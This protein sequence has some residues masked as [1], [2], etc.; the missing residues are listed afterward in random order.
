MNDTTLPINIGS[1]L[2]AISPIVL[3]LVLLAVLRWK[4]PQAGPVGMFLAV[5]LALVFFRTPWQTVAVGAGKGIWDA[6]FILLVIWPALL[7]YRIGTAAGAFDALRRGLS[8]YSRNHVFLVLAFGWVFASFVQG[9][10]GFGAPIAIVAPLLLAIGVRAVYAVAIPLIGHAWANMFGT[11][12]VGWLATL[13]VVEL[14]DELTTALVT[15]VLLAPVTLMAGVTIAWMAG[16]GAAVRLAWPLILIISAI[17]AGLQF[18]IMYWEPLLSNFLATTVALVA[19]YPLSRW[20]RYREPARDIQ[21]RPAMNKDA[22][23]AAEDDAAKPTMS[24]AWAMLPYAALTAVAVLTLAIPPVENLLDQ[25]EFGFPFPDVTTGYDVSSEGESPYSPISPFTHPGFA[26]IVATAVTWLA[27][28]ARGFFAAQRGRAGGQPIWSSLADNAAPASVAILSF[29]VLAGVMEHS[30][31]TDV[32]AQGIEAVSPPLVYA[33][34]AN[35]IGLLGAFMTSSNTASNV[36]FSQ[37]QQGVA[38]GTGLSGNAIIAA[39]SAGG[40]VG[41]AIAP[42]NIVLGTGT[43]GIVGQEGQVLRKTLPWTL[44]AAVVIGLL[45]LLFV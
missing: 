27:F 1:W 19:L 34:V 43:A 29:L 39:Q 6:I 22:G 15:A 13:Q 35:F 21:R 36:L 38:S 23:D 26:L 7:L 42:A 33:F 10:A 17:H 14:D 45:T 11:L 24:L 2:L 16:R 41:N 18:V 5:L 28:R 12:A 30:G 32:L 40:A 9:I 25:V 20:A 37:L 31:L 3:L 44:A 8:R 4:A